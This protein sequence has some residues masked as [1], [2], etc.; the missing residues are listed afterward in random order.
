MGKAAKIEERDEAVTDSPETIERGRSKKRAS[1]L[2]VAAVRYAAMAT[3]AN[4]DD[5]EK[6]FG[7]AKALRAGSISATTKSSKKGKAGE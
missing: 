2:R 1:A 6:A 3:D 5:V 7:D 4:W